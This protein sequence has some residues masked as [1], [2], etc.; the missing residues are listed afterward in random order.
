M[1]LE[2]WLRNEDYVLCLLNIQVKFPALMLGGSE[3]PNSKGAN[4][5]SGYCGHQLSGS[6]T[7]DRHT[8]IHVCK[9]KTSLILYQP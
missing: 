3:S 7:K 8:Y 1:R 6:Q 9:N 4:I 2:R 5:L